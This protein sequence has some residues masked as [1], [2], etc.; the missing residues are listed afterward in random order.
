MTF[1]YN[2]DYIFYFK[3]NF[4]IKY[5]N[6]IIMSKSKTKNMKPLNPNTP[7]YKQPLQHNVE[8]AQKKD[9]IEPKKIFEL[10]NATQKTKNNR[11]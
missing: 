2:I 10:M 7:S 4:L 11:R 6:N 3:K 9:K 1:I 8:K 5:V